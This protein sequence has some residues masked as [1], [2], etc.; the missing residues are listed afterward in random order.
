MTTKLH[1][2]DVGDPSVGIGSN[3]VEIVLELEGYD[4]DETAENIAHAK[5]VLSEALW[6]IWDNG[7]V[8]CM[9]E[10]ELHTSE[11]KLV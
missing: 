8:H 6:Q 1:F 4:A 11:E 2:W 7:T 9:T 10:E 5:D 3:Q